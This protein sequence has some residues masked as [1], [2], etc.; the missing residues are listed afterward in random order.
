MVKKFLKVLFFFLV[1]LLLIVI[2]VKNDKKTLIDNHSVTILI[3]QNLDAENYNNIVVYTLNNI[4]YTRKIF[5]ILNYRLKNLNNTTYGYIDRINILR[6]LIIINN[7]L[8]HNYYNQLEENI[9]ALANKNYLSIDEYISVIDLFNDI[10]E[11]DELDLN[12]LELLVE[13]NFQ[14]INNFIKKYF[15]DSKNLNSFAYDRLQR[16]YNNYM[17]TILKTYK[18]EKSKSELE[19]K[20]L[21]YNLIEK[22]LK[23]YNKSNTTAFLIPIIKT[24]GKT[25]IYYKLS[26]LFDKKIS[27]GL[28]IFGGVDVGTDVYSIYKKVNYTLYADKIHKENRKSYLYMNRFNK[29]YYFISNLFY[30][31]FYK[32]DNL[33]IEYVISNDNKDNIDKIKINGLNEA[34]NK[35]DNIGRNNIEKTMK[36]YEDKSFLSF[37]DNIILKKKNEKNIN[38]ENKMIEKHKIYMEK[39]EVYKNFFMNTCI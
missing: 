27:T 22:Q 11:K 31:T 26:N 35:I 21:R 4:N 16:T 15:N 29:I 5:D 39:L 33:F 12:F 28:K 23:T 30:N 24:T 7:S 17:H 20:K 25:F 9:I 3:E 37:I 19:N 38:L 2:F 8:N 32:K 6:T 10:V 13:C 1:V 18:T 36:K 14:I 34:I